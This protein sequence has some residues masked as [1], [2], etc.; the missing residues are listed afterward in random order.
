[1]SEGYIKSMT[2]KAYGFIR[3]D[4]YEFFFHKNDYNG[5][6]NDLFTDFKKLKTGQKIKVE[7][8][9]GDSSKGPCA[10]N[11]RRKDW[12]NQASFEYYG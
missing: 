4:N 10:T 1:M 3:S 6:W 8:D 9:E 11:V 5:F 2:D 12:P 7:F